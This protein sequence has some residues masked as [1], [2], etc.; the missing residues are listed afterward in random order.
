[1]RPIKFRM[2]GWLSRQP[3][4]RYDAKVFWVSAGTIALQIDRTVTSRY[5][6]GD[7]AYRLVIP[8][9]TASSEQNFVSK[10]IAGLILDDG[11]KA[12]AVCAL[13]GWEPWIEEL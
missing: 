10:E 3:H 13:G 4:L 8:F 6:D 9:T 2:Q 1:M 11:S 5:V 12:F 7:D